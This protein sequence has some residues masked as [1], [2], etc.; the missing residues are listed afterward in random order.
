MLFDDVT[1]PLLGSKKE[2]RLMSLLRLRREK[3]IERHHAEGRERE[4]GGRDRGGA[5][6]HG[7]QAS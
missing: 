1:A 7:A 4:R 3:R 6:H 5:G 2:L